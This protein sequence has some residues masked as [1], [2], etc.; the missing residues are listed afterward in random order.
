MYDIVFSKEASKDKKK[1][2][3]VNLAVKAKRL[4]LIMQVNPFQNPPPYEKLVGNLKNRYSR[5]INIQ[6]QIIYS[7]LPSDDAYEGTV[8]IH[9][10]WSYYK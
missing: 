1:L 3:S 7:V 5:R 10:M 6:H 9:R 8:Y 4:L 2:A